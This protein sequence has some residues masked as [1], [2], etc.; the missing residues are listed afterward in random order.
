MSECFPELYEPS[1]GNVKFDLYLS[2]YA[3]KVDLKLAELL[4]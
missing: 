3:T 2:N 4:C 1:G